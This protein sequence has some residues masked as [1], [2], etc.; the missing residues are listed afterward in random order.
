M[1]IF[2]YWLKLEGVSLVLCKYGKNAYFGKFFFNFSS[3]LMAFYIIILSISDRIVVDLLHLY[4]IL[5]VH[6]IVHHQYPYIS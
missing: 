4:L 6:S 2:F 5:D 1:L 3:L